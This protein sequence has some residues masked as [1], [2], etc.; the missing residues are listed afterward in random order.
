MV[1]WRESLDKRWSEW[2]RVEF[3]VTDT[4]AG[5]KV[6][7]VSGP[8]TPRIATPAVKM[9]R[10]SELDHASGSFEAG[11]AC[12]CLGELSPDERSAFLAAWHERLHTGAMVVIADR[13]SEGCGTAFEL[14]ELFAALGTSVDV[15]VGRTFWWARY[16]LPPKVKASCSNEKAVDTCPRGQTSTAYVHR[17]NDVEQV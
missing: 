10:S 5:R 16:E 2:K 8:R 6:L 1:R 17:A 13:R 11:L 9:V 7:R 3:E 14:H 4:L 15:R 12:F